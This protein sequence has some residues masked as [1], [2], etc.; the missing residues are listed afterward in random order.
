MQIRTT[1]EI[2]KPKKFIASKEPS[3]VAEALKQE[4]WKTAI[5]DE[6]LALQRNLI[7]STSTT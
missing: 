4:H 2:Y 5:C 6:Y 3:S 1:S 7:P